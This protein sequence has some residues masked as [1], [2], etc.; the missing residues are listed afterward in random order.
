MRLN[1]ITLFSKKK[2]LCLKVQALVLGKTVLHAKFSKRYVLHEII[3][4]SQAKIKIIRKSTQ[5]ILSRTGKD[6]LCF[7][8]LGQF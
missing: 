6:I 4:F 8:R 2:L 5:S 1:E 7:Y 3:I